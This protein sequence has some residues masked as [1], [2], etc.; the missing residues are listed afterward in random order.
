MPLSWR[1]RLLLGGLRAMPRPL[2]R[3]AMF[4]LQTHP[5]LADDWGYHVRRIHYYDPLPDFREITE[6]A[7]QR[8]RVSPAIDFDGQRHLVQRLAASYGHELHALSAARGFDF[9]NE[10][11]AGLDAGLYYALIRELGPRQVVEIGSGMSTRIA[12]LALQRN[13][14]DGRAGA[15]TC[16]EPY[17]QPRLTDHMPE[18]ELIT[19]RIEE[20]PLERFDALAANDILFI[21]SSHALK[22]GGDVC[23]EYLEILPRLTPGVWIHVHDIFF[24]QDYPAR[25]LV[26]QRL[27][28]NEQYLLE[29]FLAFNRAFAVRAVNFWLASDHVEDVRPLAP[30]GLSAD[31]HHG[32]GSFWMQR[33]A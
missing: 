19:S 20:V 10:Y 2:A 6:S 3:H 14:A 24:P 1:D 4:L 12:S 23:R 11:F 31:D 7:A 22:F 9:T 28:F 17:P 16:I 26:D 18:A 21:D 15:L 32:R 33:I 8:R 29:A 25:W 27:A 5:R 13:R 30:A